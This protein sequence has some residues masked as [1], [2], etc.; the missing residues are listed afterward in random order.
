MAEWIRSL[1]SS[2]P[3]LRRADPIGLIVLLAGVLAA[4]LAGPISRKAEETKQPKIRTA[5]KLAGM[6]LTMLGAL[7]TVR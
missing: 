2:P 4:I 7:I 5:L 6:L 3:S 1:F